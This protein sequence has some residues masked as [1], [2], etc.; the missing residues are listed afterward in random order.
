MSYTEKGPTLFIVLR[1]GIFLTIHRALHGTLTSNQQAADL[2]YRAS[3][4]S[5]MTKVV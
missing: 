1:K 5:S 3:L 4:P 2:D